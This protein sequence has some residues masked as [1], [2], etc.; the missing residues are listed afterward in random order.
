M[1]RSCLTRSHRHTRAHRYVPEIDG[2]VPGRRC[3]LPA[4][5]CARYLAADKEHAAQNGAL[6]MGI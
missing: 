3:E 1:C 6:K 5:G 2:L 4:V